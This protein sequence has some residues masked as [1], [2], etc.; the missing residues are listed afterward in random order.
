MDAQQL[1][2]GGPTHNLMIRIGLLRQRAP[3]LARGALV[4]ALF[5]W[6]PLALL[7]LSEGHLTGGVPIPFLFDFGA[8][9]RLLFSLPLLIVAEVVVGPRLGGAAARFLERGLVKPEERGRFE[10]AVAEALRLRNSA[11]LEVA[12][13][14]IAYLG[15]FTTLAIAF[16]A[17]VSTWDLLVTPSGPR[18][19]RAGIWN[20]FAVIPLYQFL[21]YRTLVRL[22]VWWRFLWSV[23]G[24]DLRLMPTHPDKA[25]GLGFLGGAQRPIG[26][27]AVAVSAVLSGRYCSE[28]LYA[29]AALEAFKVPVACLV[30]LMLLLILGP[31]L[32]FSPLL[33]AARRKGLV[34]YGGL[35]LRYATEF[36]AK[37]LRGGAPDGEE[38]LGS[39]DIQSL[40][41]MGGSFERIEQMRPVPFGLKDA[42]SLVAATLVPLIPV[43]ATAM[44]LEE[45]VKTV[46]KVLG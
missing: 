33:M 3:E 24:L 32:V 31:L 28:I 26:L 11:G 43:L 38:L 25:G 7:S 20:T 36:D 29:G 30:V 18:L 19:T 41:D 35:A 27:L 34:E 46:L 17:G 13:L 42:T 8:H 15:S 2:D 12:V 6:L 16:T 10:Q 14:V 9:A 22:L 21:V 44:P 1:F 23:S 39:G 40:A 4:L 45:V 37:W 5:C